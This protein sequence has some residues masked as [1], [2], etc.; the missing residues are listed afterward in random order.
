MFTISLLK[1]LQNIQ[2]TENLKEQKITFDLNKIKSKKEKELLENFQNII[3][4]KI[5]LP[6]LSKFLELLDKQKNLNLLKKDNNLTNAFNLIQNLYF[7]LVKTVTTESLNLTI[8]DNFDLP[9]NIKEQLIENYK[10][11]KI[12]ELDINSPTKMRKK[13]FPDISI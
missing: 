8:K 4:M 2:K 3:S 7:N 6:N 10:K 1:L 12:S 11:P 13:I 9:T 5:S